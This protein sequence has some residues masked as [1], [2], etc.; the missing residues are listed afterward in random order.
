[1]NPLAAGAVLV[2]ERIFRN[3]IEK[4]SSAKYQVTGTIADPKVTFVRVF[5]KAMGAPEA[6]GAI[7][8]APAAEAAPATSNLEVPTEQDANE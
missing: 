4:F 5:P 1:V 8:P 3:Q 6:E 7:E 2:G